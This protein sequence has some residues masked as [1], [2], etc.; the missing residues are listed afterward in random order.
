MKKLFTLIL[1]GAGLSA[2]AQNVGI[3]TATPQTTLE[4]VGSAADVA[5]PDGIIAPK[6]TRAQLI[7]KTGYGAAQTGAIVYVTDLSGTV[8]A[9][10]ATTNVLQTGYYTFDGTRWNTIT[11]KFMGFH[12]TKDDVYSL[13]PNTA[14]NILFGT[15]VYDVNN[16]YNPVDGRFTPKV[17]GYYQFN[18]GLRM[19]NGGSSERYIRLVKTNIT[20]SVATD[21]ANGSAI[22]GT[23]IVS[24][25]SAVVYLNGTTDYVNVKGYSLDAVS[26]SSNAH[27]CYFQ[28]Y[29]IGQ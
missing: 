16:W 28:G 5:V 7:A 19:Y 3:N 2:A 24:Q 23:V 9:G 10:T 1:L 18:A 20:T 8:T 21:I 25:V 14:S 12:A 29:L 22:N 13:P 4:V 26:S 15:E 27:Q 17:P 6:L 11:Q